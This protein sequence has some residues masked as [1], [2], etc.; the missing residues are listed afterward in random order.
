MD[1][2]DGYAYVP[3]V[4]QQKVISILSIPTA[5]LSVIGSSLI[6]RNVLQNSKRTPYRRI[7][8]SMS[9]C[10][11]VATFGYAMQ[12]FLGPTGYFNSYVWAF[13]TKGT[14][15]ALGALS[16]FAF[17]SHFYSAMLSFY[18]VSSI[19]YGMKEDA[20]AKKYERWI[21]ALILTWSIGTSIAGIVLDFF[22]ANILGPG[23]WVNSFP[24]ECLD[25][26]CDV[27][28]I[29]WIIGGLPSMLCFC[30][31]AVNNL[32]LYCFVR[33]TVKEGERKAFEN[34]FRLS[35]YQSQ[36][37]VMEIPVAGL[38]GGQSTR[39]LG[40]KKRS[41]LRSSEKQW[42]RV[43]SVGRQSFLYV[44]AYFT[45]YS[46]SMV[47]HALDGNNFD[48]IEGSG[49]YFL[50][51]LILQTIFLPAQGFLNALI[52][53]R[54]NYIAAKRKYDDQTLVWY[55]RRSIVGDKIKPVRSEF[56][57]YS[58]RTLGSIGP[59]RITFAGEVVSSA[60]G[61]LPQIP[62]TLISRKE[63]EASAL[64]LTENGK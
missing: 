8:L 44:S 60:S 13:G 25:I 48:E 4:T 10:D 7:L 51:L 24:D 27:A 15:T 3:T 57:L 5:V 37:N 39:S 14:C 62:A 52:Y 22:R 40:T 56:H 26:T 1:E 49:A 41:V 38:Q 61:V 35:S 20:F 63:E 47:K 64:S 34:E 36:N 58:T 11:I 55:I 9:F 28:L 42:E 53:F 54:P 2:D 19:R 23:C 32:L 46:F 30:S 18:F 12:P 6:I 59:K 50:P 33:K 31:I 16:Q 45:C 29:G 43:R 17:T 21:H